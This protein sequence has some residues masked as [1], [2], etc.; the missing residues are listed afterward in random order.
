MAKS[1]NTG[2]SKRRLDLG[3]AGGLLLGLGGVLGGLLLEGGKV[4]DVTQV[5][6]AIIVLGGTIGA[7]LLTTP[8]RT[9]LRAV[10]KLPAILF[11][12][13]QE[14]DEL[15]E[16]IIVLASKAR[17]EGIVSLEQS[18][19]AVADPFLRKELN[20]AVDGA[21]LLQLRQIMELEISEEEHRG[22]ADAKVY[23]AAGG[24]APT[25]GIIG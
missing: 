8:T 12:T 22:E 24:Y 20:L 18:A 5:S 11:D 19:E 15:I 16:E 10:K 6:A 17:M 9:F 23:E 21:D 4:Q 1:S 7:V 14:P 3:T 13:T 25:I 2:A